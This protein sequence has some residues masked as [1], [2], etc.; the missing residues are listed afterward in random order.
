MGKTTIGKSWQRIKAIMR[1][2]TKWKDVKADRDW[3]KRKSE[4]NIGKSLERWGQGEEELMGNWIVLRKMLIRFDWNRSKK[5]SKKWWRSK[6]DLRKG[7]FNL[8]ASHQLRK[9]PHVQ[10]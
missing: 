3:G 8:R 4:E 5:Y 1:K 7:K 9:N 10:C 6:G 2:I